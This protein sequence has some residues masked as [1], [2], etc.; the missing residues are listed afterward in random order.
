MRRI[1]AL[2]KTAGLQKQ[3]EIELYINFDLDLKSQEK[4][5]KERCGAKKV[6]FAK[7]SELEHKYSGEIKGKKFELGFNLV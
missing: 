5:I 7:S 4:I 6:Y 1:Q 2:R 3:N